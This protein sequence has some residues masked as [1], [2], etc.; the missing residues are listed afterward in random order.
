MFDLSYIEII[1]DRKVPQRKTQPQSYY[2]DLVGQ[3]GVGD[4]CT[5]KEKD[6]GRFLAGVSAY[7]KGRYALYK[8]PKHEGQY[9]FTL[10]R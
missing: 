7:S 9:V 6:Y 4:W 3:M 10:T 2:R 5:V 1:S 8:H